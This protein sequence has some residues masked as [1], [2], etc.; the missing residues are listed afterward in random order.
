MIGRF[1]Q[2]GVYRELLLGLFAGAVV[3]NIGSVLVV[4]SSARLS[5]GRDRFPGGPESARC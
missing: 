4:L 5:P 1:S 2:A 3:R